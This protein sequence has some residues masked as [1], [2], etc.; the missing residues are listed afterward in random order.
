MDKDIYKEGLRNPGK[1]RD[2]GAE[3][4]FTMEAMERGK[5]GTSFSNSNF[6]PFYSVVFK[7]T[8]LNIRVSGPHLD[9]VLWLFA[10]LVWSCFSQIIVWV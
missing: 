3:V 2:C 7:A 6:Q 9:L 5:F 1:Q 10:L 4:V 8:L